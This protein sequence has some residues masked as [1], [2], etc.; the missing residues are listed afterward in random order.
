MVLLLLFL[1]PH[2]DR[3]HVDRPHVDSPKIKFDTTE[4]HE[5][6]KAGTA[7]MH[8]KCNTNTYLR[9]AITCKQ[10]FTRMH[11]RML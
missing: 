6:L 5:T 9:Q 7:L 1:N 11:V 8:A 10:P 4:E 2:V 3:P